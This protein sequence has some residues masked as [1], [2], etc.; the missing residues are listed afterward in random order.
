LLLTRQIHHRLVGGTGI[1][2]VPAGDLAVLGTGGTILAIVHVAGTIAT[3]VDGD[4]T[5]GIAVI[6]QEIKDT[7]DIENRIGI[8]TT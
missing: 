1:R 7:A 2:G 3:G 6:T 4:D 5:G 8:F